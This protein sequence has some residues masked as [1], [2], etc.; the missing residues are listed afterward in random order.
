MHTRSVPFIG[1]MQNLCRTLKKVARHSDT[2]FE[3]SFASKAGANYSHPGV[4]DVGSL[5]PGI[6]KDILL[7]LLHLLLLLL[8]LPYYYL[9]SGL[10]VAY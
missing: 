1:S 9:T 3:S 8:L 7:L 5:T 4:P 10:L 6:C 2:N